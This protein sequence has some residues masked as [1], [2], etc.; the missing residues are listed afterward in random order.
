[1][2]LYNVVGQQKSTYKSSLIV[3]AYSVA[4]VLTILAVGEKNKTKD[5]IIQA[6]YFST[7]VTVT[8]ASFH[9]L[10]QRTSLCLLPMALNRGGKLQ[11]ALTN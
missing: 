5:E 10:S 6:L 1:M 4:T 3:S 11:L 2:E 7:Y 9:S 8:D